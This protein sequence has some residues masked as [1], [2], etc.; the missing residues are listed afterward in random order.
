[1]EEQTVP[2][3]VHQVCAIFIEGKN[4]HDGCLEVFAGPGPDTA[5]TAP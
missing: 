3:L 5:D 1:M 2:R 4:R